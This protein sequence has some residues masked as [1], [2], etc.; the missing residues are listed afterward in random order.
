MGGICFS[1]DEAAARLL[2]EPVD[3]PRALDAADHRD[4]ATV[5]EKGVDD[6]AVGISR[7]RMHD[8]SGRLV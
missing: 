1:G 8:E 7:A 4:S 5:V 2:I 3:D 6:R